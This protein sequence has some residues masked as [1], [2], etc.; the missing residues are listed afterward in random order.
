MVA[1]TTPSYSSSTGFTGSAGGS[2]GIAFDFS[3]YLDRMATALETIA[4]KT[5]NIDST[6]TTMSTTLT[7][8]KTDLDNI[9][10]NSTTTA[11][12]LTNINSYANTI[13]KLAAGSKDL[14][15]SISS[16]IS[17]TSGQ[18]VIT[19]SSSTS[20]I[21]KG[22]LVSGNGIP[23]NTYVAS[24]STN[25][26][27]LTQSLTS[28]ASGTY[29]FY[30]SWVGIHTIGPYE[31][32][33]YASQ[34]HLYVEQGKLTKDSQPVTTISNTTGSSG[35]DVITTTDITG[36]RLIAVGQLVKGTGIV[37]STDTNVQ[38]TYVKS[39]TS[40]TTSNGTNVVYITL[41]QNLTSSTS[42][43][44][45]FYDASSP[46]DQADALASLQLYVNK[47][48]SLPTSF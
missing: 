37:Y 18:K 20:L 24:F 38:S 1:S 17:G 39:F 29:N 4:T 30:K 3:P 21:E 32:L 45:E 36:S 42:G 43:T 46:K 47:I 15:T 5:T 23:D 28:T 6:L 13:S 44:Y 19:T 10:S 34:Y 8:I 22:Q 2:T 27:T 31:W 16:G 33:N 12:N 9:S 11:N 41:T 35:G 14:I 48:K 25:T 26:V 7:N 40:G